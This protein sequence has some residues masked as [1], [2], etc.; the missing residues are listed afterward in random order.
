MVRTA[1]RFG[2]ERKCVSLDIVS[3]GVC[4]RNPGADVYMHARLTIGPG[5]MQIL[6]SGKVVQNSAPVVKCKKGCE[7]VRFLGPQSAAKFPEA[8]L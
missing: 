5:C 3:V 8:L 7:V 4:A 2:A 6:L 1:S